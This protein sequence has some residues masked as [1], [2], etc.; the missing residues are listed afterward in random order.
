M[1]IDAF[2]RA[3]H[4]NFY[5]FWTFR[6]RHRSFSPTAVVVSTHEHLPA[7]AADSAVRLVAV[8]V[9][10]VRTFQE[11]V[12]QNEG[13]RVKRIGGFQSE[14]GAASLFFF[15]PYSSG[16]FLRKTADAPG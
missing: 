1:L 12:L 10:L 4:A 15:L 7:S 3:L 13:K 16:T 8:V 5:P 6:G 9:V 11:A 14:V 2:R